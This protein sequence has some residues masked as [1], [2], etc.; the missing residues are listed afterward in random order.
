MPNPTLELKMHLYRDP[1][2]RTSPYVLPT[3]VYGLNLRVKAIDTLVLPDGKHCDLSTG[4]GAITYCRKYTKNT[5]RIKLNADGTIGNGSNIPTTSAVSEALQQDQPIIDKYENDN[6]K[7]DKNIL[8]NTKT[9]SISAANF[10]GEVFFKNAKG[11]SVGTNVNKTNLVIRHENNKY[12]NIDPVTSIQ[13]IYFK[14]SSGQNV[15]LNYIYNN[16][17]KIS[18]TANTQLRY[19]M[20]YKNGDNSI[21]ISDEIKT[22]DVGEEITPFIMDAPPTTGGFNKTRKNIKYNSG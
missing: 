18:N 22:I 17:W 1:T 8:N 3:Y 19:V 21:E 4:N 7:E 13:N 5:A 6:L 12:F 15:K 14:N 10:K 20:L 11:L 2:P 16:I 9:G